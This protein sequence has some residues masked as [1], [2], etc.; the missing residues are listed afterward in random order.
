MQ[1]ES[2]ESG[3]GS[4]DGGNTF[5]RPVISHQQ[6]DKIGIAKIAAC[7]SLRTARQTQRRRKLRGI[8]SIRNNT[9]VI[10]LEAAGEKAS[11][12]PRNAG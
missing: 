11:G 7:P 1:R 8:D 3:D 9:N 6:Q 10:A 2:G 5:H 4:Q 12:A